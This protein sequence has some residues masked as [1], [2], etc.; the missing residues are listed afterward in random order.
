[1]NA[2]ADLITH[3]ARHARLDAL[4]AGLRQQPAAMKWLLERLTPRTIG[5]DKANQLRDVRFLSGHTPCASH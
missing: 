4:E 1:M 5:R 3:R 2:V